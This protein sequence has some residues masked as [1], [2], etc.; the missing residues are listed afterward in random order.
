MITVASY[1]N[2]TEAYIAK[3]LLES[4]GI[5]C[6][7]KNENLP[8]TLPVGSVELMVNDEDADRAQSILEDFESED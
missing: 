4:E 1:A 2:P 5:H 7:L 8:Q 6:V 3:G